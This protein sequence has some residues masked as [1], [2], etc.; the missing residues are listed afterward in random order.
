MCTP[1]PALLGSSSPESLGMFLSMPRVQTKNGLGAAPFFQSLPQAFLSTV[2]GKAMC[3][4]YPYNGQLLSHTTTYASPQVV[5][6][7]A[8][9]N[10]KPD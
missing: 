7:H 8:S 6:G 2:Q 10:K 3:T 5:T 1:R 4:P 9:V